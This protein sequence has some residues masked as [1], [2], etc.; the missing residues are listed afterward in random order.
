MEVYYKWI[1]VM[2]VDK[3][4]IRIIGRRLEVDERKWIRSTGSRLRTTECKLEVN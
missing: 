2:E 4:L 3:K 1:K